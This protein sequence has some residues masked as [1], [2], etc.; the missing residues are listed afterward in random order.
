MFSV[1]PC[2]VCFYGGFKVGEQH[3]LSNHRHALST[4]HCPADDLQ[5]D[6]RSTRSSSLAPPPHPPS[7]T[8]SHTLTLPPAFPPTSPPFLS[9]PPLLLPSSLTIPPSSPRPF[10]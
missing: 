6:L 9:S 5:T 1:I 3:G 4:Q 10:H 7:R 8:H 2:G